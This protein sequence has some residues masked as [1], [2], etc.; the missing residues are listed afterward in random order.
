MPRTPRKPWFRS[1]DTWGLW[2]VA[3]ARFGGLCIFM[4]V[5]AYLLPLVG[6]Q[7][8]KIATLDAEGQTVVGNVLVGVGAF[9]FAYV[10]VLKGRLLWSILALVGVWLT[11][12]FGLMI[13][14]LLFSR[15]H[16]PSLPSRGSMGRPGA[17][18]MM[19][20]PQFGPDGRPVFTPQSPG[21]PPSHPQIT[22][23]DLAA[24]FGAER[25]VRIELVGIAGLDL[26]G[27]LLARMK[28]QPKGR[29]PESWKLTH[30]PDTAQLLMAPVQEIAALEAAL[31]MGKI[32]TTDA[33]ARQYRLEVDPQ[34]CLAKK[35]D[36][37]R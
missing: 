28:S 4:G 30:V 35:G 15:S 26:N 19:P 6:L 14:G 24:R 9:S 23:E 31:D 33:A 20:G 11:S 21:A 18:G 25:V 36:G 29:I 10:F 13:L 3:I 32:A 17:G 8:K 1:P 37:G 16:F 27:T 7:W 2:D 5:G 12:I 22:Y 34:K